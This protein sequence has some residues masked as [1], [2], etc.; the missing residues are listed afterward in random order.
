[1]AKKLPKVTIEV[2]PDP[3]GSYGGKQG[4]WRARLMERRAL[5]DAGDSIDVAVSNL[6]SGLP[7]FGRSGNVKDYNIQFVEFA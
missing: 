3:D 7:R 4:C 5:H 6:V 1:M 2:Y